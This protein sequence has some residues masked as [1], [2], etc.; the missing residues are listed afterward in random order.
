MSALI[1][2]PSVRPA[3]RTLRVTLALLSGAG[4]GAGAGVTNMCGECA[5][6]QILLKCSLRGEGA[7]KIRLPR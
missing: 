3:I 1:V 5:K 6:I 2:R 7:A 4:L